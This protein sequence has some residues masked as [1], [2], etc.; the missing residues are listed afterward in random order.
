[1]T[2][3]FTGIGSRQTPPD[4]RDMMSNIAEELC[5]AGYVLRSG[6]A[7]GADQAFEQGCKRVTGTKEIYIPWNSFEGRH[8][9]RDVGV[10][11]M[12]D[13]YATLV[14]AQHHPN[15]EACS[16][17]TKKLHTRNV[18]QVLGQDL[19]TPSVCVICWTP[20]GSGSGGTGQAIR[21]AKH[22]KIPVFDLGLEG[23]L[24]KMI[25]FINNLPEE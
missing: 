14:A 3:Y 4:I 25:D 17:G 9:A 18:F 20:N 15:W 10:Y 13:D 5:K 11:C 23:D 6:A 2:R 7:Q 12:E 22:F 24:D 21:M 1:M 16:I 19:L 8:S